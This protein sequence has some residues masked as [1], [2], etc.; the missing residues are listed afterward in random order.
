LTLLAYVLSVCRRSRTHS[1]AKRQIFNVS[2]TRRTKTNDADRL[3][4]YLERFGLSWSVIRGAA[5]QDNLREPTNFV[6]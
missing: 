1:D 6:L 3:R 4:K 2:R 5:S